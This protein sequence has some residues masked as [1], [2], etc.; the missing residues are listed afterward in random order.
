MKKTARNAWLS[1]FVTAMFTAIG[2]TNALGDNAG[3]YRVTVTNLTQAQTF[4]P[5][6]LA[7]HQQGMRLFM[8]GDAADEALAQLAEGGDTGPL[9]DLLRNSPRVGQVLNSGDLLPPGETV[10]I[11]VEGRK[12]FRNLS[13]AAMLIP[14][15]DAFVALNGVALPRGHRSHTFTAVAYDAGSEINDEFCSSIPGGADCAGEGY[16]P[17]G[18]EGFIHVHAGIHGIGDLEASIYDWRNP[19]ARIVIEKVHSFD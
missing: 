18:G 16:D 13:L 14:T 9:S 4:T 2:A 8:A 5:I 15:N 1:L 12:R 10:S 19:V 11:I 6:L 17:T 7:T 3:R